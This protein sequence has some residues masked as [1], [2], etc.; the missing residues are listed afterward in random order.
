MITPGYVLIDPREF[1]CPCL[2]HLIKESGQDEGAPKSAPTPR[3]GQKGQAGWGL[4]GGSQRP[5]QG[6]G[7]QTSELM[8]QA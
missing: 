6:V 2:S 7:L 8:T 3:D 1:T 4:L 5:A